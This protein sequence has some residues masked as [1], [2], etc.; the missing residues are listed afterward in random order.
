[1]NLFCMYWQ[2]SLRKPGSI[3]LWLSIPFV[4]MTI[5]TLVFGNSDAPPRARLAV[6]DQDS[7][8]VSGL[9]K[10]AF[11]QGAVAG[12]VE[13]VEASDV[14]AVEG[15]FAAETA[16]AALVIPDGFGGRLLRMEPDSLTLYKNPRHTIMP[17]IA[18]GV[19]GAMATVGNGLIGQFAGPMQRVRA[20]IDA[21]AEPTADE[22]AEISRAF[23]LAGKSAR[24]LSALQKIDVSVVKEKDD[25]EEAGFNM[26]AMFFP[27]LIMFGLLSVSLHLEHRLL[28]DRTRR[29][30][31]RLVTAPIAPWS[32]ALQQRLYT[33]SFVYVVGVLSALIGGLIWRIPPRGLVVA[34]FITIA[35]VLFVSGF[36]GVLFSASN[37]VRAVSAISSIAMTFLAILGGGF[38]PAEFTPPA[39]Q[40]V[41][42]FFPTGMANLGLTHALT[43]RD[44]GIS[45]P[46]LFAYC[47]AFFAAGLIAGRRRIL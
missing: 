2:R 20:S 25:R 42:K 47:G 15:M 18:E 44:P 6:V 16:S 10:G 46:V 40:A 4:F 39:F 45:L 7:S 1:M 36:N 31:H 11:G 23:F 35:L 13:V 21:G 8:L 22:V 14:A 3:L 19:V 37:S 32:V 43:G 5:Y 33:A 28:L 27:G 26:A 17:Q 34:N 41:V 12:L 30:T 29:V 38:F 9:V 24:G